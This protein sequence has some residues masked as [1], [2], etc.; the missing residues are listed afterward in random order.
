MKIGI[1]GGD[2]AGRTIAAVV[3]DARAADADGSTS[4][5]LPQIFALD[6][7]GVLADPRDTHL[8]DRADD[9]RV[10]HRSHTRDRREG[11]RTTGTANPDLAADLRY[12]RR[13]GGARARGA[14]LPGV[15]LPSVVPGDARSRGRRG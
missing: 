7:M 5:A 12:D 8:G 11:S 9:A 13:R 2:T 14:R 15:R 1:F 6:A 10:A 3:A 4:Y